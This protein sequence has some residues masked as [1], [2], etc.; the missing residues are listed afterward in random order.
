MR[1]VRRTRAPVLGPRML[2]LAPP[3]LRLASIGPG[4]IGPGRVRRWLPL[5]D[6]VLDLIRRDALGAAEDALAAY[7]GGFLPPGAA[8][9]ELTLD[10]DRLEVVLTYRRPSVSGT[11]GA[12]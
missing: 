3:E 4:S 5:P 8:E 1:E 2:P 11:V 9:I 10:E 6:A 7:V 12:P